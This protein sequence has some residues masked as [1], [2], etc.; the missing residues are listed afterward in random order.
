[1]GAAVRDPRRGMV[2]KEIGHHRQEML[3]PTWRYTRCVSVYIYIY[4]TGQRERD[5]EREREMAKESERDR[6]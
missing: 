3:L 4:M 2:S 1:M 5:G 6:A